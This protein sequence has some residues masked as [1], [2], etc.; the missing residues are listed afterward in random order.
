[1][2]CDV[3][4]AR[5]FIYANGRLL[6]QRVFAALFEDGDPAAVVAALA[7]YR[8]DDG[9][10]G[11]GLEPDKRAPT[12]QPLDAEIAFERLVMVGAD[13]PELVRP[14]CDWLATVASPAGALPILLP[15][16]DGYP[17]AAHWQA[18][19]YPPG[20]NPTAGIAAH[21]HA[22]GVAHPWVDRATEYCLGEVEAGRTPRE[23]HDLLG[24]AKL[25]GVSPDRERA[26]RAGEA[27]AA[28]VP[29][30]SFMK[31]DPEADA[32]GVTPL[33]FAPS[34]TSMARSWFGD[35]L[36]EGHLEKLEQ[37]QLDDGGWPVAWQPPSEASRCE[38]R[39]IR[40]IHALMVLSAYGC[41]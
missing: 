2:P 27:I 38:W 6:E 3:A 31:L 17:R 32:Y 7:A 18:T 12:S 39:A 29:S 26:E 15:S 9:G 36:I 37:E 23:A 11:H 33:D 35:E 14:A 16:I 1:M 28:A 21:V 30:A 5:R 41:V 34:P 10:F 25:A 24:L 22:L 4:A 13:A 20:V 40:T 8:N 19:E